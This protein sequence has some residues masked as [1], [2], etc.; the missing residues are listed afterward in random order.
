MILINQSTI[1]INGYLHV[2]RKMKKEKGDIK[3]MSNL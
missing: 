3:M 1:E 2:Y